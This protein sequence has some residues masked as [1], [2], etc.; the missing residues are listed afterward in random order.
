M[1]KERYS[2]SIGDDGALV[3]W[4]SP[5]NK[6]FSETTSSRAPLS[7]SSSGSFHPKVRGSSARRKKSPKFTQAVKCKAGVLVEDAFLIRPN[8]GLVR[9]ELEAELGGF[10][11]HVLDA[12]TSSAQVCCSLYFASY[13][14]MLIV[15]YSTLYF[16]IRYT[17]RAIMCAVAT[18][19]CALSSLPRNLR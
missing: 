6:A 4:Q 14:S 9:D 7:S 16:N 5:P 17:T 2:T 12:S 19:A 18:V 13:S 11:L 15:S 10:L 3:S 8:A 1:I